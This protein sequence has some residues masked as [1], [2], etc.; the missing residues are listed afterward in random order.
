MPAELDSVNAYVDTHRNRFIEELRT[1]VRQPSISSQNRGVKECADLIGQL[2]EKVG[3]EA[4]LIATGGHPVVFGQLR[5]PGA[6]KTLLIYNH[7]DVQPVEPLDAWEHPPFEARMIGDRIVGRGSTDSKGNLLSHIKAVEAFRSTIGATP[8][9]LKFIFD[10]EEEIGSPN[11]PAFVEA[12]RESLAADA[13][14]SFDGGFD[15]SG[16]PRVQLGSSGLL[17]IEMRV[18]GP[19]RDLHS[20]RA[21]LVENPAWRLA[22]ALNSM[23]GP[24]ERI[25][26]DGF[27]DDI[28]PPT[29]EEINAL[30]ES[31]W[32]D[33]SHLDEYGVERFLLGLSGIQACERLLF[34][35]TCN[36]S[37][38]KAGHIAEGMKTIVPSEAFA[39]ID[40]RLVHRQDPSDIFHKVE[41]HLKRH[42]FT[43]VELKRIAEIEPS[44]TPLRSTIAQIVIAAA[45]ENYR[46]DPVVRPTGEASGRQG[47]WLASRLNIEGA[48]TGV[49][50]PKWHGHAPNEFITTGHLI[51]GIK[52]AANIWLKFAQA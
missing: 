18:K 31:G 37:G 33:Q 40:F 27:Y 42:G 9:N 30:F 25:S 23:K 29:E 3:I 47:P 13:A 41:R 6:T 50:P 28:V 1:L 44:R 7:Y 10:G 22:W 34:H 43:D 17:Y 2:M 16:R 49:G 12:H 24:D 45:K 52:Y 4:R 15:A 32:D 39:K 38:F 21:R 5:S 14:L 36:V 35:P 8:I 26:I 11:L 20:G 48:A 51:N 46:L 19:T